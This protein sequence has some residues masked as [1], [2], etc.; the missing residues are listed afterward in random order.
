MEYLLLS[1]IV[2]FLSYYLFKK[3]SGSLKLTQL[4]MISW[5]FYFNLLLQMFLSS[6]L[7]VNNLDD[8]YIINK[9]SNVNSILY[10]YMAIQYTMISM[11]FG[12]LCAV[13][14]FGYKHNRN[15][16]QK[17]MYDDIRPL[18]TIKDSYIRYPLYL[19]SILCILS[20]LYVLFKLEKIPLIEIM[21]GAGV[22]ALGIL[23][24]DNS[25]NFQG[26]IYIRNILAIG[27]TPIVSYIAYA[28]YKLTKS[29]FDLIWF[30]ILV[31]FTF[32][33]FTYDIAKSPFIFYLFG[34][35]FLNILING[36]IKKSTLFIFMGAILITLIGVYVV[37]S[38]LTEISSFVSINSG[39]FG[40]ILFGQSVGVYAAL[41]I[42]PNQVDFI[43]SSSIS[44]FMNSLFDA[45]NSER[46][47]RII[48]E[49]MFSSKIKAGTA[50]AM[51]SL[52]I[53][54]AWANFGL[55]GLL[56]SP[57]YVGFL[58]QLLY[59]ILL[60]LPKTPLF[61]GFFTYFSYRSAVAG[62]FNEYLYNPFFVLSVVF[63]VLVFTFAKI[64]KKICENK[65]VVILPKINTQ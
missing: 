19:I 11:P 51:S 32:L 24:Q 14:L 12:M 36:S 62:G 49:H 4:N 50:G 35:L 43:G 3:V 58:I 29:K 41:D 63:I 23:R 34:F 20:V 21:Q 28:Y 33:I 65:G 44:Q 39:I 17:Y 6:I 8:H 38:G 16:F 25:R 27:F 42:F 13:Y 60:K 10:G 15:I 45:N 30:L 18:L 55:I 64:F 5:I 56:I 37:V 31:F 7:I 61:L 59:L 40:R 54:E 46:S 1:T 52:F 26:N 57:F 47:S 22:E 2:L 53:A 48:M 9:I